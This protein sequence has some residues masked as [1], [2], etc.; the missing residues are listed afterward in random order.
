MLSPVGGALPQTFRD[1]AGGRGRGQSRYSTDQ[2]SSAAW[3]LPGW[4]PSQGAPLTCGL[5]SGRV[6]PLPSAA[7]VPCSRTAQGL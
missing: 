6:G 7:C 3:L 4:G 2:V 1:T 5:A